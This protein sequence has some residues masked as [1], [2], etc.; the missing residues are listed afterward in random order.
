MADS[1]IYLDRIVITGSIHDIGGLQ[2]ALVHSLL[3]FPEAVE[4]IRNQRDLDGNRRF[5]IRCV[6]I[7]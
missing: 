5:P 4:A 3:L 7:V 6:H 2:I 1:S